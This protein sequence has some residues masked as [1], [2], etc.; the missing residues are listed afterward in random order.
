MGACAHP[1]PSSGS[2]GGQPSIRRYYGRFAENVGSALT[3]LSELKPSA[4]G[5]K[6]ASTKDM[7]PPQALRRNGKKSINFL[8]RDNYVV[9]IYESKRRLLPLSQ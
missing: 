8:R 7:K 9:Y 5:S 4:N 1:A 3:I 6:K 2:R